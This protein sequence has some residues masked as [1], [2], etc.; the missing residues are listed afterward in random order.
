MSEGAVVD[1]FDA[2]WRTD[3]LSEH[4]G[5]RLVPLDLAPRFKV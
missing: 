5:R 4:A 2:W 1:Q 3:A